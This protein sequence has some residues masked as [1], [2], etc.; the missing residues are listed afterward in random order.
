MLD[1]TLA[2]GVVT[3]TAEGIN[4]VP[5][6]PATNGALYSAIAQIL[7]RDNTFDADA[8]AFPSHAAA[9]AGGYGGYT[10]ATYLVIT[11]ESHPNYRKLMRAADA[12]LE[13]PP[14]DPEATTQP[15][16]YVVI[17]A[18]TG[19]PALHTAASKGD[20]FFEGEVN[21]V[22]VRTG[23]SM[24]RDSVNEHTIDE[25]AEITGIPASEI[26]RMGKEF[27]SHGY[28]VS[29]QAA[30]ASTASVVG[31]DTPAGRELLKAMMGSNQM[32]GGSF[33]AGQ[34]PVTEG[35]GVCYD[36]TT[37]AGK[38]DVSNKNAAMIS[39]GSRAWEK[40]DEYKARVAAGEKDP[41]P[42]LPWYTNAPQS[43]AQAIMSIVNKYPYQC[44]ILMTWMCNVIQATPG[45][46]RDEVIE[47]LKDTSVLPLHIVCDIVVGEMAQYADYIIP[48]VTQY[49][50]FGLPTV[51]M[52]GGFGT[53]IRWEAKTPETTRLD[54]DRYVC[55]ETFLIDVA[56]ACE[57]PGWGENAIPDAKGEMHPFND[58]YDYYLK[59]VANLAYAVEPVDDI[60]A[61]EARIQGLDELGEN[62]K[63]AVT[64]EEWPKVL[65]VLSR[66]GRYWGMDYTRGSDGRFKGL[67]AKEAYVYNEKRALMTNPYS[68]KRLS[69][70]LN[71]NPQMFADLS[72]MTDHFS[73]EEYPFLCSEHKPKFRSVTMLANSPIMRDIAA[74]NYIEMN[75]EDAAEL[76]IKDGDRVRAIT[77]LGDVTEG[78]AMVRAGQVKGAFAV[79]FGYEHINYGAQDVEIDGKLT[80]GDPAIAAGTRIHMMVDPVVAEHGGLGIIADNDA[81]SPGRCGGMFKIEKA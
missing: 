35:K 14:A 19:E 37:I 56:K 48:D 61:E 79:A 16:Y 62:W 10:N 77:P 26:E 2:N 11:D 17:D 6:K 38:P 54:D 36:L 32:T 66:G 20:L 80:K 9:L 15:T 44:K 59:G 23:F 65:K 21:G 72:L 30:S 42:M 50:S 58:A 67:K 64:A 3:P 40:T 57:L 68:G 13:V 47:K 51:S 81:S 71:Y 25:Y 8:M 5:I 43:D 49:E 73:A 4:W 52:I 74:H 7:I 22:K 60:T 69:P 55:W 27:G 75:E 29:V 70:T 12:G 46:M 1:P 78:E 76:G 28:K 53:T 39:R 33:P 45:A 41:K 63:K 34:A 31:F 24:L 18:A